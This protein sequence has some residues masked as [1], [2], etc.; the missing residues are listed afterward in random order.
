MPAVFSESAIARL[1]SGCRLG[2]RS[3]T[4]LGRMEGLKANAE[5][6][7]DVVPDGTNPGHKAHP[8]HHRDLPLPLSA[9]IS[10]SVIAAGQLRSAVP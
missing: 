5:N 8:D 3:K 4:V 6:V 2:V 7:I 10:G 1:S 9:L